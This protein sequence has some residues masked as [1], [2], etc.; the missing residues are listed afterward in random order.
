[1]LAACGAN[2]PAATATRVTQVPATVNAS[3]TTEPAAA[4]TTAP[5]ATEAL[6]ATDTT[7]PTAASTDPATATPGQPSVF[8]PAAYTFDLV[9]A[10][11]TRPVLLTH[12]GDGS[13]RLFVVEQAGLISL[14]EANNRRAE[15]WLDITGPVGDEG[16]EQGLLGLAFSPDFA[17][18]G[19]FYIDYTDTAGDTHVDRCQVSPPDAGTADPGNCAT[20]LFVEQPYPN[21]NGGH[22]AFGPDGYLYVGLGDGGSGG[23][24]QD[25]AQNPRSLLGK[26]LRL[27]V[28]GDELPYAIPTDNPFAGGSA[29]LGRGEIWVYGLRNPWRFSFDRGTGD[30]FIGDV[31]QNA[32]EEISYQAAGSPGGENYGWNYFEGLHT[33][34]GQPS[35][36]LALVPPI[37]EYP[38]ATGGCSV[39]GGYV[40]RGPHFP[41]LNGVY[42]YGDYCT[43]NLWTLVPNDDTW[44]SAPFARTAFTISSFGED[45]AGELYVVDHGGGAVFRIGP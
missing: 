34:E 13:Q 15:P 39:T 2:D 6:A 43:G 26:L 33:F 5:E 28:S 40:Y 10:G 19:L 4:P 45:E 17:E 1:M 23:D 31:G 7:A 30:L 44:S 14:I 35:S 29:A 32:Y 24:P 27:D 18:S 16:N 22:L 12:A 37:A 8:D 41:E 25:H 42:F 3:V 21:H 36:A 38:Q 9:A 11:F 20:I